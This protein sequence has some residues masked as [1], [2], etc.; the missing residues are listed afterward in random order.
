MRNIWKRFMVYLGV[1]SRCCYG[2]TF[3]Y[4]GSGYDQL[5]CVKCFKRCDRRPVHMQR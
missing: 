4:D 1:R 2:K 5:Y 3:N